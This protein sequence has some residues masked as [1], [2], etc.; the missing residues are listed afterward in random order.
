MAE[1]AIPRKVIVLRVVVAAE[2]VEESRNHVTDLVSL[3][4]TLDSEVRDLTTEE[5]EDYLSIYGEDY[6]G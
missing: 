2:C 4:D 3:Y 1:L 6:M 5:T